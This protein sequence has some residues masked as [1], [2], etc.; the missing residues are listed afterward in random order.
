[1]KV[2]YIKNVSVQVPDYLELKT[3]RQCRGDDDS[4]PWVGRSSTYVGLSPAQHCLCSFC[5]TL[6]VCLLDFLL[7]YAPVSNAAA[8]LYQCHLFW[9]DVRWQACGFTLSNNLTP[10]V[11]Q[12]GS[13]WGCLYSPLQ[14][15][16]QNSAEEANL[17]PQPL[18]I[19][20]VSRWTRIPVPMPQTHTPTKER[21]TP[22]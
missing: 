17:L 10:N 11:S 19:R 12:E 1:M 20:K 22:R 16:R 5:P 7:M 6:F 13:S 4:K 21:T 8:E 3:K 9:D 2:L 18:P 14:I 15:G